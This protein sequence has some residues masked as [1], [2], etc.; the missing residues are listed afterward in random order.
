MESSKEAVIN[1]AVTD[2]Y[3]ESYT[4]DKILEFDSSGFPEGRLGIETNSGIELYFNSQVFTTFSDNQSIVIFRVY[5][6]DHT[7]AGNN[8]SEVVLCV[9]KQ[10]LIFKF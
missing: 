7:A 5:E 2:K 9:A 10:E 6:M 3:E 8:V 1:G 4:Y